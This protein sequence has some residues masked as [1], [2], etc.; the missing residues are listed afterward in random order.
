[1]N[2]A[3]PMP[4]P[5]RKP[6]MALIDGEAPARALND[7]DDDEARNQGALGADPA[8]HPV[9]DEHRHRGH[10]QV[11]GE[12]QRDLAGRSVQLPGDRRQ[13]RV[14]QPDPHERHDARERDREDSF[15]LPEG[16]DS[17]PAHVL[18][19]LPDL[20]R[21]LVSL[22]RLPAPVS[23]PSRCALASASMAGSAA[24]SASWSAW[25]SLASRL[26]RRS[27]LMA[28]RRA[29][30]SRPASVICTC[31]TRP[32][33]GSARP[34]RQ[35]LVLKTPDE[36]RHGRLRHSLVGGERGQPGRARA[37]QGRQRGGGRQGQ[38]TAG[39]ATG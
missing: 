6:M 39:S 20:A 17:S 23:R 29:T 1:M 31:T 14:D 5:A 4:Q 32:S 12:Q 30:T 11:A 28:R 19:C 15:R 25:L 18:P 9:G 3:F 7:D 22:F 27:A 16:A 24:A 26:D 36:L 38:A 2:S 21:R 13:D 10:D 35:A 8:R 34:D 33:A 37:G